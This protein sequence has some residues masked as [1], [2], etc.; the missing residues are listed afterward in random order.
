LGKRRN[1]RHKRED[2]VHKYK[3]CKIRV[4]WG[5]PGKF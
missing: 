2:A 1:V 3:R 4:N 5:E